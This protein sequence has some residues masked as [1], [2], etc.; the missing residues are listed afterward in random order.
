FDMRVNGA[1]QSDA[2]GLLGQY[3]L[4]PTKAFNLAL[5]LG[6]GDTDII[7]SVTAGI[8]LPQSNISGWASLDTKIV[9][10]AAYQTWANSGG[11]LFPFLSGAQADVYA[12]GVASTPV[13][14]GMHLPGYGG[15]L[16][17]GVRVKPT[18]AYYSHYIIDGTAVT[19]NEPTLAPEMGGN[20]YLVQD[21]LAADLGVL[22]SPPGMGSIRVAAV[23]NNIIQPQAIDFKSPSATGMLKQD[24]APTTVSVGVALEDDH[25]TLAADLLDVTK[26]LGG[27]QLRLGAELRPMHSLALRAG[28]TLD[29]LSY[30]LGIGGFNIAIT[31]NDRL[32]F[33]QTVKF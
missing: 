1:S 9:P 17:V 27:S 25:L 26:Q 8:Q 24:V 33:G 19:N 11:L 22:C 20:Q 5:D 30:G 2:Q 14:V 29:G 10:N 7:T 4:D 32:A 3:I 15:E 12:V 6:K 21:S 31:E 28:Y 23:V 16:S 13:S 18:R